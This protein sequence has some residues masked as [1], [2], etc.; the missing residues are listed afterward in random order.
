MILKADTRE[1]AEALALKIVN[2]C[3]YEKKRSREQGRTELQKE[4]RSLLDVKAEWE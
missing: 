2:D 4:F 1:K 3:D